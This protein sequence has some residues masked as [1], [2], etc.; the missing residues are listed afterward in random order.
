MNQVNLQAAARRELLENGFH[1]DFPLEVREQVARI[2]AS[3]PN[4]KGVP[5][6][7]DLRNLLWSSIDNDTS[8]DLDQIEVAERLPG[9]AT[10]ILIGIA[11]V[12]AYVAKGSPI[13]L[14]AESE[15]ATLYTGVENFSM[16]PEELS[17]NLTSLLE[18]VVSSTSSFKTSTGAVQAV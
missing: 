13:D 18:G 15:G 8:R 1:P 17:M 3:A 6:V 2:Q 12:A 9:G 16:L 4:L 11:D 5:S 7:R 14:Y 10:R